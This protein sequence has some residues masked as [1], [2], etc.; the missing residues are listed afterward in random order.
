MEIF[1]VTFFEIPLLK[2]N[3]TDLN[4]TIKYFG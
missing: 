4:V 3:N 1:K 2:K